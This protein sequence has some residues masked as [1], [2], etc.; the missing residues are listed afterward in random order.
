MNSKTVLKCLTK[1]KIRDQVFEQLLSQITSGIWKPGTKI[2]SENELTEIMGVSRISIR[3][4]LQRLSA[5]DLV[6]TYRGKGTFVKE[7]TAN[8]YLKSLTP[9]LL[10]TKQ[11]VRYVVQYRRILEIGIIEAYMKNVR[12]RDIARLQKDL[13]KMIYYYS[14]HN[15]AKYQTYDLDFHVT[16][17]EMTRNPIILKITNMILDILSSAMGMALTEVG[18]EEGIEFHSNMLR[19]IKEGDIEH[20]KLVVTELFDKI[21]EE[22]DREEKLSDDKASGKSDRNSMKAWKDLTDD[23]SVSKADNEPEEDPDSSCDIEPI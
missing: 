10:L 2:P 3:E 9:M 19:L 23:I 21:E 14:Q 7:F 18:A 12:K 5:M 15:L 22:L 6:E 16:L 1:D 4:A 13:D 17:Y 11:D 20:L 8:N